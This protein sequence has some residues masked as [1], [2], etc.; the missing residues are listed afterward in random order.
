MASHLR[1]GFACVRKPTFIAL[2]EWFQGQ[3]FETG[4]QIS[5]PILKIKAEQFATMLGYTDF[6]CTTGWLD[7][8]EAR[9]NICMYEDIDAAAITSDVPT[10]DDIHCD[11]QEN[12]DDSDTDTATVESISLKTYPELNDCVDHLERFIEATESADEGIVK[13]FSVVIQFVKDH[14]PK[15]VKQPWNIFS[16]ESRCRS[17]ACPALREDEHCIF[18]HVL[19]VSYAY[20]TTSLWSCTKNMVYTIEPNDGMFTDFGIWVW[21]DPSSQLDIAEQ[22]IT[23]MLEKWL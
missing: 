14:R 17:T 3:N 10:M 6:T 7:Q 11:K 21:Y 20:F 19:C 4:T 16:P 5:G 15:R 23:P 9:H 18:L 8:F 22:V 13:A 12:G 2:M 1:K